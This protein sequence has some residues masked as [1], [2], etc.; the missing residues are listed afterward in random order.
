MNGGNNTPIYAEGIVEYLDHRHY[1]VG[2][3]GGT[4]HY[5][6]VAGQYAVVDSINN[7]GIDAG[8]C[9]LG[10]QNSLG[11]AAYMLLGGI[12]IGKGATAF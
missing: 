6:F 11:T 2:G 7:G 12:T 10:K 5:G 1:T 9:W 8:I 4:G 3:A